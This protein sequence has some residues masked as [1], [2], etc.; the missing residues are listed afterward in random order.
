MPHR[1]P[2][3]QHYRPREFIPFVKRYARSYHAVIICG[4]SVSD[5][6]L[7]TPAYL[8]HNSVGSK[9]YIL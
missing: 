3:A 1:L 9:S 8:V 7:G 6:R 4:A 2:G 5:A